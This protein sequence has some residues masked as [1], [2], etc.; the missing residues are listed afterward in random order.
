MA[1][2]GA[3][4]DFYSLGDAT[5]DYASR[6]EEIYGKQYVDDDQYF[7]TKH[8]TSWLNN[9]LSNTTTSKQGKLTPAQD[10]NPDNVLATLVF[11][12]FVCVVLLG[13]YESLRRWIPSVYSQRLVNE[14]DSFTCS[15]RE[16]R[17]FGG[18]CVIETALESK[19]AQN[20]QLMASGQSLINLRV[21]G[22]VLTG[23]SS[24]EE[25]DKDDEIYRE[26]GEVGKEADKEGENKEVGDVVDDEHALSDDVCQEEEVEKSSKNG[27]ENIQ[28]SNLC[29]FPILEWCIPVHKTP[30]STLRHL[31]GL[32]AYFYLRYIRMCLK[33]TAVSSF[34]A[35]VILGP[36]YAT[37][38]GNQS[39]FY[40]FSMANVMQDDT[41][42]VWVPTFFCWAFTM[43]CCFCVRAEMVHYIELRMEFLGGEE[44]QRI[45]QRNGI[46]GRGMGG[47]RLSDGLLGEYGAPNVNG[48]NA[49][50]ENDDETESNGETTMTNSTAV[51]GTVQR[52]AS[53]TATQLQKN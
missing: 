34:W 31:A 42:R 18:G 35:L 15:G 30:W 50:N 28:Q 36:V 16:G 51:R 7:S 27:E 1:D 14:N 6:S 37:G 24:D 38:G 23:M 20:S 25:G 13:L 8:A 21:S 32:D 11:N 2:G 9:L 26:A 53:N 49:S 5:D 43:Y 45:L 29:A 52:D 48:T 4:D 22:S 44:E 10:V 41:G 3:Y 47:R 39:G 40:Y 46:M 12:C 17:Q 19:F 33:I